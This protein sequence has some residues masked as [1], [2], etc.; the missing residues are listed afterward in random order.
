MPSSVEYE[1]VLLPLRSGKRERT[2]VTQP[3]KLVS[4]LGFCHHGPMHGMLK[5]FSY[6]REGGGG[7]MPRSKVSYSQK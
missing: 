4:C 2:L 7:A 1:K 6:S 3:R 5:T